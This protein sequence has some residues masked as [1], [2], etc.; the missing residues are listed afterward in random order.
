LQLQDVAHNSHCTQQNNRI[1]LT[2]LSNFWKSRRQTSFH[3]MC[4]HPTAPI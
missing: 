1:G 2:K 3:Q 4:G